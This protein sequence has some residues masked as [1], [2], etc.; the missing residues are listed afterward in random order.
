VLAVAE[1]GQSLF[2]VPKDRTSLM[3][4]DRLGDFP[5]C[6]G[7]AMMPVHCAGKLFATIELG[8][9]DHA[10][11]MGDMRRLALIA[12]VVAERFEIIMNVS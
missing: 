9:P 3:I 8:R 4:Q 11:R 7:V 2:G 1:A 12:G 6:S 10:F 5:A